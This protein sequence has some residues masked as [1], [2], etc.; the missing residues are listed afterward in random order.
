MPSEMVSQLRGENL[1][2]TTLL[3]KLWDQVIKD[4]SVALLCTYALQDA[5]D[6]IP[7]ALLDLHSH[8]IERESSLA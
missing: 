1:K 8:N 7:R 3:E 6:Y 2:A 4:H 5:E